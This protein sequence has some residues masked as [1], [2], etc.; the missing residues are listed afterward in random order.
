MIEKRIVERDASGRAIRVIERTLTR[1]EECWQLV[2]ERLSTASARAFTAP[3]LRV[4]LTNADPHERERIALF[5]ES[6]LV[7]DRA[8]WSPAWQRVTLEVTSA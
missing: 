7:E 8:L 2:S 3:I 4:T 5:C 6:R 1:E